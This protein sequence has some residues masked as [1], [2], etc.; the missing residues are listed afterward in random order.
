MMSAT[1]VAAPPTTRNRPTSAMNRCVRSD[2]G[3]RLN[4]AHRR[5]GDHGA[6]AWLLRRAGL[7]PRTRGGVAADAAVTAHD[8]HRVR[9]VE[10]SGGR[11]ARPRATLDHAVRVDDRPVHDGPAPHDGVREHDAVVDLGP[12]L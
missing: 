4:A 7:E 9:G 1:I 8:R 10:G 11:V 12:G 5:S 6:R 3:P 2:M